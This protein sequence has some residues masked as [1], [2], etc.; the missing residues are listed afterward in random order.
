MDLIDRQALLRKLFPY[1]V[2]DKKNCAINAYAVE[3]AILDAPAMGREIKPLCNDCIHYDVCYPRLKV[4]SGE[5]LNLTF[6]Q[7]YK[8][9]KSNA[10]LQEATEYLEM[11]LENWVTW[12]THH[13]QLCQAIEIL[14]EEVKE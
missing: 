12:R 14:L 1:E 9:N 2:V 13:E 11:V 8:T 3:K 6:C 10:K 4:E 5:I 7:F